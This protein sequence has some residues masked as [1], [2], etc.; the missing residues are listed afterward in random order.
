MYIIA[1][2]VLFGGF[3]TV[4][5]A[6]ERGQGLKLS[7]ALIECYNDTAII[8]N[9]NKLPQNMHSL[10]AILRKIEDSPLLQMDLRQLSGAILH[11]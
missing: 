8:I 10:I 6:Q 7:S 9:N 1:I 5:S 3:A 4:T 11:R 2:F